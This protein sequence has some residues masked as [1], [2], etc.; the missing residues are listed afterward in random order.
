[1]RKKRLQNSKQLH[2]ELIAGDDCLFKKIHVTNDERRSCF[3]Q[4]LMLDF[5]CACFR[6][7]LYCV[8]HLLLLLI[9]KHHF[10][11]FRIGGLTRC[12][13]LLLTGLMIDSL[14]VTHSSLSIVVVYYAS[15]PL[16]FAVII[17][18]IRF[19]MKMLLLL[20]C[21]I[22]WLHNVRHRYLVIKIEDECDFEIYALGMS[23]VY[24]LLNYF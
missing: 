24:R 16:T 23:R 19:N 17:G 21:V 22:L 11:L 15:L 9:L 13:W 18:L 5:C 7:I 14:G 2:Q 10:D 3:S 4:S 12:L 8:L 20:L 1:M 6:F